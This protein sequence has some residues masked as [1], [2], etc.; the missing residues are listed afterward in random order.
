MAGNSTAMVSYFLSCGKN[1]EALLQ[2]LYDTW[3][4]VKMCD[5]H[6][7]K[8]YYDHAHGSKCDIFYA[9]PG[10]TADQIAEVHEVLELNF[11]QEEA[12]TRFYLHAAYAAKTCSDVII[13]S[14]DTDVLVIGILLQPL[15][16]AHL[17]FNTGK[18]ADLRTIDIKAIQESIGDDVRQ[19][20]IGLHRF[21][22]CDSQ[23]KAFNL[24][25]ND[26]SLCS[27]F[28]DLGERFDLLP[29]IVVLLEKFVCKLYGQHNVEQVNVHSQ[30]QHV[31]LSTKV[32][33]CHA[34]QPR[35]TDTAYQKSKVI[36]CIMVKLK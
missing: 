8:V 14:P 7:V 15:I 25:L 22:G 18:G 5:V 11:T 12:D 2:Y 21:T 20:L 10:N 19:S 13:V 35:C 29:E 34:T 3:K 30:V 16:A 4:T 26:K 9:I 31:P 24:L 23:R 27:A 1:K 32:R 36:Y 33:K 17:Y 6:G 28:K